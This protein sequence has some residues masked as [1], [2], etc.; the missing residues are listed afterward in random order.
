MISGGGNS[1]KFRHPRMLS[2]ETPRT[3]SHVVLP[4][5]W[6]AN[7]YSI[8]LSPSSS[9]GASTC[10]SSP[11]KIIFSQPSHPRSSPASPA[12]GDIYLTAHG[13]SSMPHSFHALRLSVQVVQSLSFCRANESTPISYALAFLRNLNVGRNQI[14]VLPNTLGEMIELEKLRCDPR[15]QP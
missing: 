14:V 12:S 2:S 3:L 10:E 15:Q 13:G 4:D 11:C 7:P 1:E 6:N 5:P 8:R 9:D